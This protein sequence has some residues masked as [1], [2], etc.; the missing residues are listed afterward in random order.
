M[1]FENIKYKI[2]EMN[3]NKLGLNLI[4]PTFIIWVATLLLESELPTWTNSKFFFVLF[5]ASVVFY[6][7]QKIRI[8]PEEARGK[9]SIVYYF[10]HLF[11]L[12]LLVIAINQFLER[13]FITN[14]LFY[15]SALSIGFGFLTFYANRDRVEREIEGEKISEDKA[16]KRRGEEFG[17]KFPR[18]NKIWGLRGIVKWMYKEGWW[19]GLGL[20]SIIVLFLGLRF[21]SMDYIDG[22][23]NYNDIA[24]KALYENGHSFYKYSVITTQLMLLSVKT[25]GFEIWAL[26]LPFILYSLITII[27]IYFIAKFIDKK[28]ALLSILLFAISPWSIILSKVTRDYSFDCMVGAIILYLCLLLYQKSKDPGIKRGLW[29]LF[30]L[31]ALVILTYIL[32]KFNGRSQTLI[33]LVIPLVVGGFMSYNFIQNNFK[34]KK[35]FKVVYFPAILFL[36]IF[37]SYF[38]EYFP[39]ARGYSF[40]RFYF[41]VFFNSLAESPWQ[42]FHGNL[43][44]GILVFAIFL[45]PLIAIF[46]KSEKSEIVPILYCM[47]FFGL[48]LYL[49]KYQS[50][51]GYNP[52]RYIYFLFPVSVII[53]STSF[54]YALRQYGRISL[55]KFLL[56]LIVVLLFFNF[57]SIIYAIDPIRLYDMNGISE[58]T[59][60]NIGTGR[61]EMMAVTNF[62]KQDLEWSP[63]DIYIFG[64]KYPEF[65]LLLDYHIDRQRSII[66]DNGQQY[67]VGKNMFIESSY[68]NVHELEKAIKTRNKGYFV[69]KHACITDSTSLCLNDLR[70]MDFQIYGQKFIFIKEINGYKIYSWGYE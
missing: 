22:S 20:L 43:I 8:I 44:P 4:V 19:Y 47:F 11:L 55:Q 64:G 59:I 48:S 31:L 25:F 63:G 62:I 27:F 36:G 53:F 65:I 15:I 70:S 46:L 6:F 18:I 58:L 21:Y 30:R 12:S 32:S 52:T 29:G 35:F 39:F 13:A 28:V 40:S 17:E 67:E 41:D 33:V 66:R 51:I 38:V 26:K 57:T 1:V 42:W 24:V 7:V 49:F 9:S 45:F 68:Y 69:T 3:L 34:F 23:D 14:N 2:N 61:F 56:V 16:E 50:H 5:I 54:I 10:S 37:A 60:D